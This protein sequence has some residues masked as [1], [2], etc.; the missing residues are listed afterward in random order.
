VSPT[1][2]IVLDRASAV[3]LYR[4]IEDQLRGAIR[5]GR[6]RPGARLPGVRTLAGD[7][8]VARI[9]VTTAYEQL[10]A[11]GY[12]DGRV[13]SGTRV[14]DDPP[15]LRAETTPEARSLPLRPAAPPADRTI[16]M[17][18][19]AARLDDFPF[20]TWE[21]LL[22]EALHGLAIDGGGADGSGGDPRLREAIAERLGAS[23]GVRCEPDQV[24]VTTG[25]FAALS[26]V[27]DAWPGPNA[28]AL[29]E[30]PGLP[31]VREL[32]AA[33]GRRVIPMP[34]DERGLRTDALPAA[35][36]APVGLS[37][38]VHA[39]PAWG[40]ILGGTLSPERRREVLARLGR[41]VRI[42]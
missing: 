36:G 16:D 4:Q 10:A 3:P 41:A 35:L 29:V 42:L 11:E 27:V 1:T 25:D 34:V 32:L 9:T 39:T 2:P 23:R 24:F 18:P 12:V 15:G 28:P 22:R 7:L 40:A 30:E 17:R 31:W 26:T 6:L 38:L 20:R 21:R 19:D 37:I 33:R 5:D 13:G 8:G 14:S